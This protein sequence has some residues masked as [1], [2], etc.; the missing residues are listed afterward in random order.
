MFSGYKAR[1]R[2]VQ[3]RLVSHLEAASK[4]ESKIDRSK[5]ENEVL[6]TIRTAEKDFRSLE[7]HI[8]S[9]VGNVDTI[10]RE[11]FVFYSGLNGDA[12][13]NEGQHWEAYVGEADNIWVTY[14]S[15]LGAL[16]T[17]RTNLH[18]LEGL[19][20][21]LTKSEVKEEGNDRHADGE[22]F[23]EEDKEI[24]HDTFFAHTH[25]RPPGGRHPRRE[26]HYA[27]RDSAP[28]QLP[29][30]TLPIYDGDPLSF[31]QWWETFKSAVDD[32][33]I[34]DMQKLSYLL[35][36]L[37]G[38]ALELTVGWERKPES[39]AKI[40]ALLKERFGDK[41]LLLHRLNVELERT[42]PATA[43]VESVRETYD[44]LHRICIQLQQLGQ[45]VE[46]PLLEI[47]VEKRFPF[48][49]V[50][51]VYEIKMNDPA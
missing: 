19:R 11:W 22:D 2:L 16:S 12:A 31:T 8:E 29:K 38:K 21:S 28:I 5:P 13:K 10:N 44:R 17:I 23:S 50:N 30:L 46:N 41:R 51:N 6:E 43:K 34:P 32:R 20:F 9:A 18:E 26:F 15:A 14:D 47:A 24:V 39:Y 25:R 45:S 1:L 37:Q 48:W 3:N 4:V 36:V 27:D 49:V 33:H 42:P 40:I 7:L 35:S